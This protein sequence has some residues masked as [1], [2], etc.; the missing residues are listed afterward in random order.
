MSVKWVEEGEKNTKYDMNFKKSMA[1]SKIME[2][3]TDK[4]GRTFTKH[5]D[6]M[7]VQRDFFSNQ[8]WAIQAALLTPLTFTQ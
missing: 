4:K 6:I 5:T 2:R 8:Y 3:V 7:N 1:N